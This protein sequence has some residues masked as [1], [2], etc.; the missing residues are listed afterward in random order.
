MSTFDFNVIVT[1]NGD[2]TLKAETQY[3][4]DKNKFEFVNT[5][6]TGEPIPMDIKGSKVLNYAEGLTRMISQAS[7]LSLWK[8]SRR[9]PRCQRA[10]QRRTM[11][12]ETLI[13]AISHLTLI[14]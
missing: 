7:S 11:Q 6:S 13:L 3:P 12:T 9:V 14:C 8:P 10:L 4:K 5:Y 2:G 1:D